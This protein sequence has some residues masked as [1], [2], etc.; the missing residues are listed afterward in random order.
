MGD[1]GKW[2]RVDKHWRTLEQQKGTPFLFIFLLPKVTY[3]Q[4][5]HKQTCKLYLYIN[6]HST[7]TSLS[8]RTAY[9][10][11]H[12]LSTQQLQVKSW[13][14]LVV[15]SAS[16]NTQNN[17]LQP[18]DYF[19]NNIQG[20]LQ[21]LRKKIAN[22]SVEILGEGKSLEGENW[23]VSENTLAIV[24]SCDRAETNTSNPTER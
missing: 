11:K 4:T 17:P 5:Q 24:L 7:T 14:A 6:L 10:S 23:E 15:Q 18:L 1:V 19:Y 8:F 22:T 9:L 12:Y 2:P 20:Q 3:Q 16:V 13:E 21:L